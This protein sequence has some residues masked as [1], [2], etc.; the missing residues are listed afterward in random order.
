MKIRVLTWNIHGGVGRDGRF[1]LGRVVKLI[2][3][4]VPDIVALQEVDSRRRS[5]PDD[6][7]AFDFIADELGFHA[8]DAKT[9][10]A[11]DGEYGQMLV[12]RW[13]I[14]TTAIHDISVPRREPRRA[15]EAE[16]ET[17]EG[18]VHV[19]AAHFGLS[20]RE[21]RSQAEAL[22]RI[23]GQGPRTTVL[24]GDFNDWIRGSVQRTLA[25]QFKGLSPHRSWPAFL[26]LLRLDRVFCRP[27]SAFL[28]SWTD[29]A[30]GKMS[31]HLPIIAD[32]DLKI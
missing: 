17:P 32:I 10:V 16:I 22:A 11:K 26:P 13:E 1:D 20:L 21:R 25:E 29:P 24:L 9:I 6:P 7:P 2:R 15:I 18:P 19:V 27:E 8:V 4:W 30:G 14:T 31:D 12:S 28:R 23:A 5:A 3:G